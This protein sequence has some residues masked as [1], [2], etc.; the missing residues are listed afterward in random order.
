MTTLVHNISQAKRKVATEAINAFFIKNHFSGVLG[1]WS[2][3]SI[4]AAVMHLEA[5][6][7]YLDDSEAPAVRQSREWNVRTQISQHL[8]VFIDSKGRK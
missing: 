2:L 1:S 8:K 4:Y 5:V 6:Q 7:A 3:D